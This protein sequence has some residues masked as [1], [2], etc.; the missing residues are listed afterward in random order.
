MVIINLPRCERKFIAT[1]VGGL[2][3]AKI[4]A[5][6][7]V[8]KQVHHALKKVHHSIPKNHTISL[9]V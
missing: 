7:P 5:G 3:E 6:L 9:S 1:N 4:V 8:G 2:N